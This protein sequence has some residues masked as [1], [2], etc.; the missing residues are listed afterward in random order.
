MAISWRSELAQ[1][2]RVRH[3]D[4]R[5]AVVEALSHHQELVVL[6]TL[7]AEAGTTTTHQQVERSLKARVVDGL[8]V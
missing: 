1:P 5:P 8:A 3:E 4:D 7:N 6:V 2:M